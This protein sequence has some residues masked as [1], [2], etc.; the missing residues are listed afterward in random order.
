MDAALKEAKEKSLKKDKSGALLALKRKKLFESEIH[1]LQGAR[2]TMVRIIV[3]VGKFNVILLMHVLG[4]T[5]SS[6]G[7][8]G[9]KHRNVP[10]NESRSKCN[11]RNSRQS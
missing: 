11:E 8:C 1:K 10:R 2:I 5:S 4:F 9:S 7:K 3:S 6:I